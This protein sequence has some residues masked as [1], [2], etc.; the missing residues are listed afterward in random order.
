MI[1]NNCIT[2]KMFISW[3][4]LIWGIISSMPLLQFASI[5]LNIWMLFGFTIIMLVLLVKTRSIR[6]M[7]TDKTCVIVCLSIIVS[8]INSII[9]MRGKWS[10]GSFSIL[11]Q[12]VILFVIYIFFLTTYKYDEL[13]KQYIKGM[14]IG[15]VIQMIWS[16]AQLIF[17]RADIYINDIFFSNVNSEFG[18]TH[19]YEG[20]IKA[21]GLCWNAGN[22]V[23]VMIFG[24]SFSDSI[25]IKIFF[26]LLSMISGSRTMMLALAMCVLA[27]IIINRDE[28]K[29]IKKTKKFI[30]MVSMAVVIVGVFLITNLS[31]VMLYVERITSVVDAIKNVDAD[32]SGS[33]H[34]NYYLKIGYI[35][36]RNNLFNNIFGYGITCSGYP[37][38]EFLGQYT[39]L[40][41]WCVESDY[42]N[43][44]WN[45]GY[46][47]FII[48]YFWLIRNI[49]KAIKVNK[50][51]AVF[52]SGILF[53][54][55]F[56]N[57][58]FNWVLLLI[59]Y[60]F[61]FVR[62]EEKII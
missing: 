34:L 21:S 2:L 54:G 1:Y 48:F 40:D 19:R 4:M 17:A 5:T 12:Y 24:Y 38:S 58:I 9:V 47:G 10:E 18:L 52:F 55:I 45:Y 26:V 35:T 46:W 16:Y 14:Y 30:G 29:K 62:K 41:K 43:I 42:V 32:A 44:L 61:V 31:T 11:I 3:Y 60:I 13:V 22:L 7:M 56:Y 8:Q 25:Y 37:Y 23:P 49:L 27:D 59:F 57:V 39:F 50:Q 51:Y 53:A 20:G 33:V 15:S 36:E 6:L 28:I